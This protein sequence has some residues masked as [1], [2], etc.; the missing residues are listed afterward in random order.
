M[1]LPLLYSL[2]ILT[3]LLAQEFHER[4]DVG[5]LAGAFGAFEGDEHGVSKQVD[6]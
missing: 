2:K 1:G 4:R 3:C 5:G 6:K